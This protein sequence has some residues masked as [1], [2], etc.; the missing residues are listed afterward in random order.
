LLS[1][2]VGVVEE[3]AL[4]M[5]DRPAPESEE[6][7]AQ[8]GRD[9]LAERIA[10]TVREDGRVETLEGLHLNRSSSPTEMEHGVST[11]AFCVIAQGSKEILVGGDRYR[12]DPNHYLIT[13][14][15]LPVAVR[16]TEASEERP[17][18]GV[19]LGLDPVLVGSVMVE[20]GHPAPRDQAAV[21]A[22]DVSPLDGGLLDAVVRLVRL[23]DSP[24]E[25]AR[26]LRPLITRE[27]VFRLLKGEQGGRLHHIA[28]LGG[29]AHRIVR[30][31]QRLR[32]DF[33]R[34]LRI[35]DIARELGMSVSG[36]HHH[37]KAVTAMSPLQFQKQVRLQEAR[38]LMLGEDLDAASAG[39]R[40]GYGDAS[41]FTREY[42][43]LF[44][45][46]PMRDVE[47]LREA[48]PRETTTASAGL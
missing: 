8:V 32:E 16:I 4:R 7:G 28:A 27:I 10:R 22:I 40:V 25:E 43:R 37:F 23:Q 6:F 9:E 14:A 19:V 2:D 38:R 26:F 39:Y 33:D 1:G 42:K 35:E 24:A 30:A 36:F 48:A 15:A 45:A 46:P 41:H 34:P 31:L 12:Y 29:H 5:M 44:G 11:P 47:R 18:L 20:A 17:Y 13:T 3:E 21:R